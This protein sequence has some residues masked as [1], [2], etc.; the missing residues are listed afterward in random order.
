MNMNEAVRNVGFIIYECH[1]GSFA[2]RGGVML[3]LARKFERPEHWSC[4]D[5]ISISMVGVPL[6]KN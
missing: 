5:A 6:M 3:F 1:I 4:D 2:G